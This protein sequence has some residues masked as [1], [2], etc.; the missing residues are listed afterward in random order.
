MKHERA[1]LR[2]SER[3]KHGSAKLRSRERLKDD[4]VKLRGSARLK[5]GSV[6]PKGSEK[7]KRVKI[8]LVSEG[9]GGRCLE[10]LR[11]RPW[12][13]SRDVTARRYSCAILIGW[14]G[15]RPRS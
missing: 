15:L 7:L 13:R 6:K 14:L 2:S 8:M 10:Y 11:K 4:G 5:R 1:E 3:L 9:S 12:R